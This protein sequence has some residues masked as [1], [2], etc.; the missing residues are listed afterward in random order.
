MSDREALL[1]AVRA[2]PDADLPRL[3]YADY[4]QEHDDDAQAAFVRAEVELARLPPDDE[5]YETVAEQAAQLWRAHGRTW[6]IPGLPGRQETRR[7]LIELVEC[8][9]EALVAVPP[10]VLRRFPIRRLRLVAADMY[11]DPLL[12][13]PIW[14]LL[15]SLVLNNN[16]MGSRERLARLLNEAELPKL[17]ELALQNN[18]LWPEA[19]ELL[20]NAPV[21]PQLSHLNLSGNPIGSDGLI[22]LAESP[23]ASGLRELIVRSDE[24]PYSECI[25]YVGAVALAAS[26]HLTRLTTLNLNGHSIGDAGAIELV[27]SPNAATLIDL[28]LSFNDLGILDELAYEALTN[29]LYLPNLRRLNLGGNTLDGRAAEAILREWPVGL[30]CIDLRE[31]RFEGDALRILIP[32]ARAGRVRL[33]EEHDPAELQS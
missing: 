29:P 23:H 31:C 30:H 32:A 26:T 15:E 1:A 24:L 13:L 3:V 18:R 11:I 28:D 27:Q 4:L 21:M 25:Q 22:Q 2:D 5:A 20:L 9:A 17:R 14:S 8:S 19:M 12:S 16:L 10:D 6:R 7:G 33:D